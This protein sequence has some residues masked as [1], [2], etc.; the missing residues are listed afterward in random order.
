MQKCI[1]SLYTLIKMPLKAFFT[2]VLKVFITML[3]KMLIKM[4]LKV[5]TYV[6]CSK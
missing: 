1:M 2:T 5:A 4:A 6:K 3:L